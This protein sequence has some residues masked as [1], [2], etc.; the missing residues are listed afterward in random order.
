MSRR[1][2]EEDDTAFRGVCGSE[3]EWEDAKARILTA[4]ADAA[5]TGVVANATVP[6]WS[7]VSGDEYRREMRR[8]LAHLRDEGAPEPVVAAFVEEDVDGREVVGVPQWEGDDVDHF[9][10]ALRWLGTEDEAVAARTEKI[11]RDFAG[12]ERGAN[13]VRRDGAQGRRADRTNF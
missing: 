2:V 8:A 10:W 6:K 11:L 4:P 3:E 12:R 5:G 7:S 1:C 13:F 9:I